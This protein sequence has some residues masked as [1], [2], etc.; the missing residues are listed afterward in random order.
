MTTFFDTLRESKSPLCIG[1][2][3]KGEE[4]CNLKFLGE[5]IEKTTKHAAVFKPN[6][7]FFEAGGPTRMEIL[8]EIIKMIHAR[9]LPVILDAKRGDIGATSEAYAE[10]VFDFYKADAVTLNPY[11]GK[12]TFSPFFRPEKG[13][14]MLCRT[15]NKSARDL[16]DLNC[17]G[18]PLF[19]RVAEMGLSWNNPNLGFVAG[20]TYPSDI[21]KIRHNAPSATFLVPGI[22]K[23]QG[24]LEAAIK[25]GMAYNPNDGFGFI[26]NVSGAISD[27]IDPEAT[28]ANYKEEILAIYNK[29]QKNPKKRETDQEMLAVS[30]HD[31]GCVKTGRTFKLKSGKTSPVYMDLR[32][33]ISHPAVLQEIALAAQQVIEDFA[34]DLIAPVPHGA[35]PLATVLS[36]FSGK[37]LIVPRKEAKDHGTGNQIDGS[38]TEGQN[39]IVVEDVASTGG[40]IVEIVKILRQNRLIVTDVIVA[41]DREMGSREALSEIGCT[42]HSIFA[43]KDIIEMLHDKGLISDNIYTEISQYLETVA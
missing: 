17:N 35:T 25:A 14:F 16:Q 33:A 2:D 10:E 38:Y 22:G 12:D 36:I 23:Q 24:D 6:I 43:F 1:L 5:L 19:I 27:S 4:Q 28:A 21:A 37:P 30:L 32:K 42:L 20:A 41:V 9:N 13:I 18:K 11:L 40:S 31:I 3:P 7:A 26:I 39:V 29:A 15:S 34:Y 8:I